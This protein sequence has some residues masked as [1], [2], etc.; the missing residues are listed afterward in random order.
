MRHNKRAARDVIRVRQ[1][2]KDRWGHVPQGDVVRYGYDK[3]GIF[4]C[5]YNPLKELR[6]L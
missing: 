3:A 1:G 4:S 6:L 2:G 5:A